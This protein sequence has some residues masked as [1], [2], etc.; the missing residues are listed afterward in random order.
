MVHSQSGFIE[1]KEMIRTVDDIEEK[2]RITKSILTAL[3][4]WFGIPE[5]TENYIR[6]SA[7][8]IMVASFEGEKE[9]IYESLLECLSFFVFGVSVIVGN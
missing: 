8:E 3:P 4:E 1:A 9:N 2:Q 7:N 6:E 5:S